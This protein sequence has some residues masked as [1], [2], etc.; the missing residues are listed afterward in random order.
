MRP[1]IKDLAKY[2]GYSVTTVS[3]ALNGNKEIPEVTKKKILKA[4]KELNYVP[5]FYARGLK[6]S[7]TYNI[8]VYI[9]DFDSPIRHMIISGIA[10][11]FKEYDNR[12][13]IVV[14]LPDE[15]MTFIRGRSLDLSIIMDPKVNDSTIIDL[16]TIL[17]IIVFDKTVNGKNVFIA[18]VNNEKGIYDLTN[19]LLQKNKRIGYVL[20]SDDSYHNKQRYE[21]YKKALIDNNIEIVDNIIYNAHS[22]TEDAGFNLVD[23]LLTGINKLP[24]DVL[25]CANDELAMGAI[26]AF[27]LHGYSIPN[28]VKVTGFDN[29]QLSA[30]I[31]PSLTTISIDWFSFGI[32]LAK[33][34]LDIINKKEV[35]NSL[36]INSASIIERDSTK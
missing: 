36:V 12:Y 24:F 30:V 21:G 7:K 8:G 33:Y 29:N 17:P 19:L 26:N 5:S 4:A 20:G 22:F 9:P 13:K 27:L 31:I 35:V 28:D 2:C 18:N 25:M 11:G 14:L 34:A 3:Y 32:E 10:R 1:T 15:K 23:N 16:A 6:N